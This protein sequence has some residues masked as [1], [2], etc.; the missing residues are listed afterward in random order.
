MKKLLLTLI[1]IALMLSLAV[2]VFAMQIFIEIKVATGNEIITLEVEPTDRIEDIKVKIYDKKGILPADQK[3]IF[4]DKQLEDGN[5]LQDYSIQKDS[6]L[7]LVI[8]SKRSLT[9]EYAVAPTYTVTIPASVALDNSV[10]VSAA[11]VVVEYGKVVNVKLTG[12]SEDDNTF[13]LRTDEGAVLSY[14][15]KKG[16]TVVNVGDTV[17]SVTPTSEETSAELTFVEPASY[18]Y[19]GLYKGTVTFTIAVEA[20]GNN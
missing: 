19:A 5:T 8:P 10:T 13:K 18:T 15:V 16:E 17:L 11:D 20:A 14:A 2:P 12:T 6:T 7:R 3:L 1:A 9:V 4:A